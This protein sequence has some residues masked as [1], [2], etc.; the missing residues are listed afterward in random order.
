MTAHFR[1][2]ERLNVFIP[3]LT[4]SLTVIFCSMNFAQQNPIIK[5]WPDKPLYNFSAENSITG[6]T[7]TAG[8]TRYSNVT[9]PEIEYFKPE[10]PN[11]TAVIVCPGGGYT[12]LAYTKEGGE[13]AK[14]FASNGVSAFVL[15]YRLPNDKVMEHKEK[16]PLADVQQTMLFLRKNASKFGINPGC[17]GI[18][19]FSAGGHLAASLSTHF[20]DLMIPDVEKI[21]LRPDFSILIYPVISM[22][23][24]ITHMGSRNNL[25]GMDPSD[26]LVDFYSNEKNVTPNTPPTFLVHATND[27]SVPVENSLQYYEA[28]K[29]NNV[30]SAMHIFQQGGHGFAMRFP[31]NDE[32][33]LYLVKKWLKENNFIPE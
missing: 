13:V 9:I 11:G 1:I 16:V 31:R 21:N 22:E 26:S 30:V 20:S 8:I 15:K 5:I 24:D 23:K 2:P 7:D 18:I 32:Q 14:W 27:K 33:W 29:K 19:G 25:L 28:L 6:E 10:K 4:I 12:R 3:V 17:I